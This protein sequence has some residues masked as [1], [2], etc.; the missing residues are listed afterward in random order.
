MI[1]LIRSGTSFLRNT[2]TL[3]DFGN[4]VNAA[5]NDQGDPYIQLLSVTDVND[6]RKDFIQTRLNGVDTTG[7]PSKALLP[8][9]QMQHSPET[10]AE[11]SLHASGMILRR[12]PYI[13]AGCLVVLAIVVGFCLW[14]CCCRRK[15]KKAKSPSFIPMSGGQVKPVYRPLQDQDGRH[16]A[17]GSPYGGGHYH[18]YRR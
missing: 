10:Q 8:I 4:F 15:P 13:V 9:D 14:K 17:V 16:G 6:A 5:S 18:G 11:K 1:S 12:W 2:Y 7:D 3:I